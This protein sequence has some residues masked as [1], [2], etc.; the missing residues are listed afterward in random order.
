MSDTNNIINSSSIDFQRKLRNDKATELRVQGFDPYPVDS[1]RDYTIGFVKFWFDLVHKF[2]FEKLEPDEENFLLEYF[3][4]LAMFPPSLLET[5]E[6]KIHF[7]HTA[8]QMGIDPDDEEITAKEEEEDDNEILDE[9]KS[10]LPL[11]STKSKEEKEKLLACY[12]KVKD[13]NEDNSGMIRRFN[14]GEKITIAGRIKIK[15]TSGKIAFVVLEDE[16]CPE[17]F[18]IV[19]KSDILAQS[20][21][22]KIKNAF[23]IEN[24]KSKLELEIL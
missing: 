23:A 9:I 11:N 2:D 20:F 1:H 15:R 14:K 22:E 24:L 8:R 16:S 19:F 17:G 12:L 21:G 3:L 4:S 10:L 6:E 18:Q 5:L 7:R 13:E